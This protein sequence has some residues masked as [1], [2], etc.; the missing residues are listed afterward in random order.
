MI[1]HLFYS[2][3]LIHIYREPFGLKNLFDRVSFFR[4]L[5]S[6]F[7]NQKNK[8]ITNKNIRI[9]FSKILPI[10]RRVSHIKV[11]FTVRS[12]SFLKKSLF[13][14]YHEQ[15]NTKGKNVCFER[16]IRFSFDDFWSH[17]VIFSS[18]HIITERTVLN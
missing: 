12:Y 13:G 6:H 5:T 18:D 16:V 10:K 4:F 7:S 17:V 8:T 14:H 9:G 2:K 3:L 1:S 15:N 11:I